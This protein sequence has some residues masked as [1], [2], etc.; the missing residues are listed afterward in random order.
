MMK[1]RRLMLGLAAASACHQVR[2]Q[3]ET[4]LVVPIA[5]GGTC[6]IV[7]GPE[8]SGVFPEFLRAVGSRIGVQFE[9]PVMPRAR[10]A[11]MFMERDGISV[12]APATR[13]HAR[14]QLAQFVPMVRA[15]IMLTT[16]RQRNVNVP[17]VKALLKDRGNIALLRNYSWGDDYDKLVRQL[18]AQGRVH[19]VADPE[20][21]V[22]R[23]RSGLSDY[24]IMPPTLFMGVVTYGPQ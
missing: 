14:D 20:R 1:T 13:T 17:S 11:R 10:I 18:E 4:V 21:V 12:L 24:S 5:P 19:Y 15:T 22:E 16:S 3:N 8:V 2:A 9:F 6:V 7:R 23:L